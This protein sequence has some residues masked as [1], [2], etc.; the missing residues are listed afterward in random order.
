MGCGGGSDDDPVACEAGKVDAC[1]C[2]GGEVGTQT[3][4]AD[5]SKWG[6]CQCPMGD[7]MASDPL[8]ACSGEQDQTVL[9]PGQRCPDPRPVMY[10]S[11][12]E[13][14]VASG[15]CV[16]DSSDTFFCCPTP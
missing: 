3:C 2:G 1:P 10:V 5:G 15:V 7:P 16:R 8:E 12:D 9:S 4:V 13:A 11:C 6:V 14:I